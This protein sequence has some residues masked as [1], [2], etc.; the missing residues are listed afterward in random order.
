MVVGDDPF[1]QHLRGSPVEQERYRLLKMTL[2]GLQ[3]HFAGKAVLDFGASYG[4]SACAMV[5]LGAASVVGVEPEAWR[6]ARGRDIMAALGL[7]DRI[8]LRH[9]ED[10]RHLDFP[11]KSFEVVL[12][13]AVF[14]HIPQPRRDYVRELWRVLTLGGV[15]IINET[16]NKYLPWDFHTTNLPFLNWIPRPVARQL[17]VWSGRS[18]SDQDWDR[19][20]WRGMGYYEF[21]GAIPGR[22]RMIHE[23]TRVRHRMLRALGLPSSLIDPYPVYI[24]RKVV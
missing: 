3:P 9:V 14:E 17:A 6:V 16:P 8:S 5:E 2:R 24:V 18:R 10:T 23:Q 11:D 19:S 15:L 20:G 13:N 12:A 22:Y 7:S 1:V 21:V 4:L